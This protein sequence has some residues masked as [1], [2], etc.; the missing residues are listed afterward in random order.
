MGLNRR[1]PE[2]M[3]DIVGNITVSE[4]WFPHEADSIQA[5]LATR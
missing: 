4:K 1:L 2:G 3:Q 5:S